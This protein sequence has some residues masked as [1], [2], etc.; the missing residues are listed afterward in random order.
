MAGPTR[1][2]D[3]RFAEDRDAESALGVTEIDDTPWGGR[4]FEVTDPPD[5]N[6]LRIGTA[7]VA[8]E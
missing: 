6:R 8:N 7:A 3:Q 1:C 4:D 5:R 2:P